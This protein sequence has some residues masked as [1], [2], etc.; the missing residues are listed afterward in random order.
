M[1]SVSHHSRTACKHSK[2][3]LEC[4][5]YT[6][7][8]LEHSTLISKVLKVWCTS[9]ALCSGQKVVK[10]C[11]R[12]DDSNNS[13]TRLSAWTACWPCKSP[14]ALK[15][16]SRFIYIRP[17]WQAYNTMRYKNCNSIYAVIIEQSRF[18]RA[19][20]IQY[21][22]SGKCVASVSRLFCDE[23][24]FAKWRVMLPVNGWNFDMLLE[25]LLWLT[26]EWKDAKAYRKSW[27]AAATTTLGLVLV[28]FSLSEH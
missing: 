10:N 28:F 23:F 9:D 22:S 25:L 8:F 6:S 16:I 15:K 18:V 27:R 7:K 3:M 12:F 20:P 24:A 19:K 17:R 14:F 13:T 2:A 1:C 26:I 11:R 5:V 21:T 4:S